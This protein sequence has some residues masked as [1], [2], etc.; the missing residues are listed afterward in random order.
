M[1]S[2][3]L[4]GGKSIVDH[5]NQQE[6]EL[7]K[8]R[9]LL[10]EQQRKEREMEQALEEKHDINQ[11]LVDTYSSLQQEVDI[12]TKNLKKVCFQ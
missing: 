3:L 5:T 7:E 4:V 8:K 9:L 2:K 12:K 6:K 1:E 10:A 11:V